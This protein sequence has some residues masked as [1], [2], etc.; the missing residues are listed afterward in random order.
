MII[1]KCPSCGGPVK[2]QSAASVLAVCEYCT[3]TLLRH[4]EALENI[5]KMAALQDDPTLLQ[6]GS[7]G[8]YR[9]VHFGII[10][11]IQMRYEDGLWN[12]WHILFDDMRYGWL[13]EAAGE[14][15]VTF[16]KALPAA[17]PP[18]ATLQVEGRVDL[19]GKFYQ[20]TDIESATCIAGQGELPFTVG[21]GYEAPVVD[22]RLDAEFATID[23]SDDPPR[24]F[25]GERIEAKALKL[26][27]LK[28][29][30]A[31]EYGEA[32]DLGLSAFKCPNCAAP[33]ALS[34]GKIKSYGCTSCG[35]L[36]DTGNKDVQMI[37]KVQKAMDYPLLLPLNTKG[38]LDGIEWELIGHM[39]RN[40]SDDFAWSEYLLFNAASGF[41]WLSESGGHWS[42]L[43]NTTQPPKVLGNS[44]FYANTE[45]EHFEKY[46]ARVVHVLGEF[47]WRV[48]LGDT[49]ATDDYIAPPQI[50][51]REKAKKEVTW[52]VGRYMPVEEVQAVFKPK[53][54]LPAPRGVSPNQ[55]SPFK[56]AVP[57][58]WKQFAWLTIAIL[59]LQLVF[60]FRS[61]KVYSESMD[62]APGTEQSSTTQ[63]FQIKGS[64]GSVVVRN[65][66]NLS[67]G[68]ASINYTLV[69]PKS[70]QTWSEAHELSYYEGREDGESW[71]EG[72]K[73]DEVVFYNV[74]PGEYR[75]NVAVE[76]PDDAKSAVNG[77]I[78]VERGHASWLNW[79]LLQIALLILPFYGTWR[80]RNF[81]NQRWADSDHPR[82]GG[83]DD[84]DD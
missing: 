68:W 31:A 27:N 19:G 44:A 13:G 36:L 58:L 22:L 63:P 55:P 57:R 14:F 11:R 34:S 84:E 76:L 67:N 80:A 52:T 56:A 65:D 35:A 30:R 66:T 73:R 49:A 12:E 71:S 75:L 26:A 4:G 83:D 20:V 81:E 8:V 78:A 10:G 60:A 5:G 28:D 79:L 53:T 18:F 9:G 72:S 50:L 23:Y 6:I 82:G 54:A 74:P 24:V 42:Y 51:S 48:R 69:D 21:P 2:F 46:E 70:G 1:G 15:Y 62:F 25:F 29:D 59:A 38:K 33:F 77:Q 45:F 41:R 32:K 7:E 17:P 37:D 40:S 64:T 16:E 43:W 47:Y 39:R 61:N 3:S